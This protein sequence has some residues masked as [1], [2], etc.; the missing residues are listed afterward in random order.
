MPHSV[1]SRQRGPSGVS[2]RQAVLTDLD[3]LVRL[4][5]LYREFQGQQS[6]LPA[7]RAFLTARF[8]HGESVVFIAHDGGVAVGLAQLYP[9]YSSVGL[10]RVFVLNDLFVVETARRKGAATQLL[11]A[12]EA[13][14]WAQGAARVT[15]NVARDNT[16]GQALYQAHGWSPDAQFLMYHRYPTAADPSEP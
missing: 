2:V 15:L 14:A 7:A 12:L 5:N 10:A 4:F 16:S 9:S 13:Y 6:D 8:K 11:C 1:A 3:E